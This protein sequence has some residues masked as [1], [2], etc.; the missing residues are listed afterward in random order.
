MEMPICVILLMGFKKHTR[1]SQFFVWLGVGGMGER[2][3]GGA[4]RRREGGGGL[5]EANSLIKKIEF[6][7]QETITL[8]QDVTLRLCLRLDKISKILVLSMILFLSFV[9]LTYQHLSFI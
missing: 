8:I 1:I 7:Q 6:L 4:C 3:G 2:V 9:E 5:V